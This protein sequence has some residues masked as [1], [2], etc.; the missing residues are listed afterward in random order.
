MEKEELAEALIDMYQQYCNDG[1][2]FMSA[3]EFASNVLERYG[4][5]TF[6]EAGRLLHITP[7]K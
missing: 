6:D 5:A 4:Y 1:H 7:K 2:A 3:G